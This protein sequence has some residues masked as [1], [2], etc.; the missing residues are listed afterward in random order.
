MWL[1]SGGSARSPFGI[2]MDPWGQFFPSIVE[3]QGLATNAR[4]QPPTT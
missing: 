1:I 3:H 4:N 2:A